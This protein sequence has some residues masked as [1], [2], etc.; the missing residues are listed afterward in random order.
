MT[1][2]QKFNKVDGVSKNKNTH[3]VSETFVSK[4][5][6]DIHLEELDRS[7]YTILNNIFSNKDCKIASKKNR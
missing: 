3:G 4:T 6:T 5:K 1:T 2:N 7:G